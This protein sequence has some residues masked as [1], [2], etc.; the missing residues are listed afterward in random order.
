[1]FWLIETGSL[2]SFA[3]VPK[4]RGQRS[5]PITF[6]LINGPRPNKFADVWG[7]RLGTQQ[8]S[9][10]FGTGLEQGGTSTPTS[11]RKPEK[12]DPRF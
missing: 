5:M 1:M 7:A 12:S 9:K 8:V 3:K 4:A 11:I 6:K 2:E 10:V